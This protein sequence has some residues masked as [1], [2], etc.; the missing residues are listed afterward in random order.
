MK[1]L[2]SS[3]YSSRPPR[4][5]AT[6]VRSWWREA[7]GL[8]AHVL[9]HEAAGAVGVLG[10]AGA[11]AHLAEER[12]LLV[13]GDPR[14]GH[15]A[16]AQGGRDL[17]VDLARGAD[18]GQHRPGDPEDPQQLVVPFAGPDVEEQRPRGVARV[19]HVGLSARELVDEPGVHG[20]EGQA[21]GLG[22]LARPGH[23][24]EDPADLGAGEVGVEH[25]A[26][27]LADHGLRDRRPCRRSQK[28]GG[29]A[30][31]PHDRV[32]EGLSALAVP[33]DGGLALVRDSHRGHV[34]RPQLSAAQDLDRGR[35]LAR[36]DLL[37][38]VLDG[39]GR[40]E[41][42]PEL[43]L[44]GLHD[45]AL[46]VEEDRARARGSLVEGQDVSHVHLGRRVTPRVRA[47]VRRLL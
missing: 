34:T 38:V 33:H 31:L 1:T 46:L 44:G 18:L 12:G 7:D 47:V 28:R 26:R 37:R 9:E 43:A 6:V 40:G 10:V 41:D 32:A 45:A 30:V 14:D 16:E 5:Q 17:A 27:A 35:H 2:P 19:G 42:L 29:A 24:V 15:A 4:F 8:A 39:P 36:P 3:A 13:S 11:R 25:E 22:L 23:V 21:P 20:A